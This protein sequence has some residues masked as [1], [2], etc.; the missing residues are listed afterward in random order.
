MWTV[1]QQGVEFRRGGWR[2]RRRL[3]RVLCS[4]VTVSL[5][6]KGGLGTL[7]GGSRDCQVV[8]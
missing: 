8:V 3:L 5:S 4:G 7:A 6:S 2:L 1:S